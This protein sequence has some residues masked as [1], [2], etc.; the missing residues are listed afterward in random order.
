MMVLCYQVSVCIW[1]ADDL[2]YWIDNCRLQLKSAK[3]PS[4][5]LQTVNSEFD[6]F[7]VSTSCTCNSCSGF[8]SCCSSSCSSRCSSSCNIYQV[9]EL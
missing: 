9:T 4:C 5:E 8:S 6:A 7:N 2:L 3:S 1:E